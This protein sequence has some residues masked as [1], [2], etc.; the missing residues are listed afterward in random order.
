VN[1]TAR[2]F[3]KSAGNSKFQLLFQT[4]HPSNLHPPNCHYLSA[5]KP[6]IKKKNQEEKK[7][8]N[9][10]Y[11]CRINLDHEQKNTQKMSIENG[12]VNFYFLN[13][14]IRMNQMTVKSRIGK[15]FR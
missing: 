4:I 1:T 3:Q 14:C 6:Q 7:S 12:F 9:P 8:K 5:K 2:K 13:L 15:T 11:F 10:V